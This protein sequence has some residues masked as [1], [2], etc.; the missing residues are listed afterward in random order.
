MLIAEL[1]IVM[2]IRPRG[3]ADTW[4]CDYAPLGFSS[5]YCFHLFIY[6]SVTT[7]T[8]RC[9]L[10]LLLIYFTTMYAQCGFL[11]YLS[12]YHPRGILD[13]CYM[14]LHCSLG[15]TSVQMFGIR[16]GAVGAFIGL[17]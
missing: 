14:A 4:Y 2:V 15:W 8:R 1:Y 9:C 10:V 3:P 12:T 6:T 5:F 13:K 11:A 17:S 7:V 16:F